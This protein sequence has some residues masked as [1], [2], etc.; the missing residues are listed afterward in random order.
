M[1]DRTQAANRECVGAA[2]LKPAD[3]VEHPSAVIAHDE[4][5][6]ARDMIRFAG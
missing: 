2:A 3:H 6:D 5:A 1:P 4:L